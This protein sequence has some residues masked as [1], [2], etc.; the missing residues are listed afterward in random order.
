[1]ESELGSDWLGLAAARLTPCPSSAPARSVWRRPPCIR[2]FDDFERSLGVTRHL[3]ADRLRKLVKAGGLRK[4]AYSERPKRYEYRL[5]DKGLDLYPVM[6][7]IVHW[8]DT[9]MA[10]SKGRPLLHEHIAC[11]HTFDPVM[12][13]SYREAAINARAVRVWPGPGVRKSA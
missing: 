3:L 4:H 6:M 5:T 11:G 2:R 13:C 1:M 10:G 9:H 7:A 12:S 8:G